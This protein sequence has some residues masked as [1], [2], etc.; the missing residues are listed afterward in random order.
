MTPGSDP[1]DLRKASERLRDARGKAYWR[2]LDELSQSEAF[3]ELV[4]QEF[5]NQVE[6]LSDPITRRR[7]LMLMG[8]SLALAGLSGCT[9][10][11]A[12]RE[13][14]VPYVRAPEG[15]V[16]GRPLFFA[17]ALAVAGDVQGLLVES[18]EG[19]PTKVE[20]NPDYLRGEERGGRGEEEANGQMRFGPTDAFAQASVLSL[21][22]PDRS[23]NVTNLGSIRTWDHFRA[24]LRTALASRAAGPRLRILT[25]T[26][27]S[28]TVA[29]Q[30]HA[31]LQQYPAAKLHVYEPVGAENARQGAR[32]VFGETVETHFHIDRADVIVALDADFLSTG[33]GHVRHIGAFSDRRRARRETPQTRMNRLYV[34]ESAPSNTGALAD[35]RVPMCT[36]DVEAFARALAGRLDARFQ[37]IA[38]NPPSQVSTA[39]LDALARDLQRHRGSSVIIAGESQPPFVHALAHALN[40]FLGNTN[41]TVSYTAAAVELPDAA[42]TLR[43]L[44]DDMRAGLVDVLVTLGGDPVYTAPVDMRFADAMARVPF[45]VHLGIYQDETAAACHWHIPEAHYLES[46]GDLRSADGTVSI[47][48]PL[49]APLYGGK[50]A[51]E[52]LAF[53]IDQTE[54]SSY[55]IVRS[56]WRGQETVTGDFEAWWRRTIHDGFAANTR[57]PRKAVTVRTDWLRAAPVFSSAPPNDL[58]L[59]FRPDPTIFDGRFANNGWLQELPKSLSK[60][61]WDNAAYLSPATAVRLGFAP[62]GRP[63]EANEKL[64]ELEYQGRKVMAPLWVLPGHADNCVT[65]HLGY[66]RTRAGRV[67]TGLGFNANLLRTWD[68]PWYGRGLVAHPT[69][70]RMSLAGTQHH[71]LMENRD[72]VH[73]GTVQHPPHIPPS[74]RRSLTLYNDADHPYVG[75]Q[76][77]MVIDLNV[78]V[79]CS[80][81]VV[82]CQAENNIPVV[83]KEEVQRGREMHWIRVDRYHKGEMANPETYFQPVPCMQCENAPCELVCPV[84]ATVHSSDGLNDMVYNRCVGTRYCSNNCPYKVRRFN[85]F[86][87]GDF[88]SEN[89]RPLRNPEVTVRSRG[90]M[91][92]CTYCVQRIRAAEIDAQRDGRPIRDGEIQTACQAVCPASAIIFGNINDPR[93]KVAKLKTEPLHYALLADLNTR[94]RTTYLAALKNPNPEIVRLGQG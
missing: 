41:R 65:I 36:G 46:W 33:P 14:I 87:F 15:I 35:H 58:E 91:E 59:N 64:V 4:E 45:R 82:A 11:P 26:V 56:H 8:A 17:T 93:S 49:I 7:F 90:V 2:S 86:Q 60:L 9:P 48:Q 72:L 52:L 69:G 3:R 10:A 50:T 31:L 78:C 12:P 20:G 16:A 67:G 74:P 40:D 37:P 32:Q 51:S 81:C 68:A 76:W 19:R 53:L 85:F 23:Q 42:G 71:F 47:V 94:P 80:A 13:R 6:L 54:R 55:D 73:A 38:V 84:G 66:G 43:E 92:K 44:A 62:A 83:G 34:I 21:Y 29:R 30:L 24:A 61:T 27:A 63:E 70:R 5:P 57:L 22:D 79:G 28:P 25:E 77:G 88:A 1:F 89:M 18:H 75:D 39:W